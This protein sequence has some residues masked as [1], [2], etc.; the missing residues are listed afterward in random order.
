VGEYGVLAGAVVFGVERIDFLG[1]AQGDQVGQAG[2]R[3]IVEGAPLLA[4]ADDLTGLDS[5]QALAGPVP[6]D[7]PAVGVEHEGR[8][9]QVLHQPD[10]EIQ[11]AGTLIDSP[12]R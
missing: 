2:A 10:G 3:L 11:L 5:G 6:D 7:D 8:H 1:A 4:G 9:D 12:E